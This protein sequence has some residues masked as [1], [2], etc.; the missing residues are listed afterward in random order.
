MA[1]HISKKNICISK[2]SFLAKDMTNVNS[3]RLQSLFEVTDKDTQASF[4][5]A[6]IYLFKINNRDT[7]KRCDKCSKLTIKTPD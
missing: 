5:P 7:R 4:Y 2:K 1:S 3:N 6:N